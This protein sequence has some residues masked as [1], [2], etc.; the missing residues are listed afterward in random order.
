MNRTDPRG[1]A[2]RVALL[3]AG[4]ETLLL[5]AAPDVFDDPLDPAAARAFLADPR[6]HIAVAI[7]RGRVVGFA[8]AVHY[9]HPDA[10]HPEL[11]INEV[12]VAASH[13]GRGLG[14][15]L[16]A[17]LLDTGRALGCRSAWVLTHRSN[18]RAMRLYA[19]AG[20]V[21]AEEDCVMFEFAL[22]SGADGDG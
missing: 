3:R 17:A 20:G 10:P 1:A 11:W 12:G 7:D 21:A 2:I 15:S 18:A 22:R 5:G 8:S 14:K 6:H 9:D 4:D 19:S 13:E 16:V